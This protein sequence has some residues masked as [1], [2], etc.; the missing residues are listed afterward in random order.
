MPIRYE[1]NSTANLITL[2]ATGKLA[3][4][5]VTAAFQERLKDPAYRPGMHLLLDGREAI[6]DFTGSDVSSLVEF[7]EGRR[8]ERGAGFRFALVSKLDVTFAMGR[9]FEAYAE[10]LPET[11]R[12]FRDFDEAKRWVTASPTK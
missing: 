8:D 1:I 9:V 5:D 6:F 3:Y 4:N 12:V 2:T 7:F 11:I 10:K